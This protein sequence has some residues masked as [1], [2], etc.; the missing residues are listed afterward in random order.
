MKTLHTLSSIHLFIAL[1]VLALFTFIPSTLHARRAPDWISGTSGKYPAPRYFIGVGAVS[2]EKGGKNQ[3]PEW[4]GDKARAEIAKTLRTEVSVEERAERTIESERK[5]RGREIKGTSR[6]VDVITASASEILEGAEIKEYH[7]DK[8]AKMLYALAV[9]DRHQAARR[10]AGK[11]ARIKEDLLAEVLAAEGLEKENRILPAIGRYNKALSLAGDLTKINEMIDVLEPAGPSPFTDAANHAANMK[12]IIQGLRGKIRFAVEVTGPAAGIKTYL[13]QGLSKA[14]YVT[15]AATLPHPPPLEGGGKG[16]GVKHYRLVGT[17]AL[18]Y[19]GTIAM[20][21]EMLMQIYQADLDLE[22]VDPATNETAGTLTWS[23]SANE[24][25]APMASMSAVRA[26]GRL[27][28]DQIAERL[29][30]IL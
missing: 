22:V 25:E 6:L 23:A 8:K 27:V 11:A 15:G 21:E 14:G 10:L 2:M 20:G 29:A 18:T 13:A 4:A 24:K 16:N 30:N 1:T 26:L 19:R 12:R 3:Q 17:T 9:L 7:R 5:G 28:G